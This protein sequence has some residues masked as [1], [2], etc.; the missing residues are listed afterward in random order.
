M[1]KPLR[2]AFVGVKRPPSDM[3]PG[4]WPTFVR[5]HLE[6]P[7]YYARYSACEVVLTTTEKVDYRETFSSGGS[8]RC[9]HEGEYQDS[10]DLGHFDVVVH[11]RKW[12]SD[13]YDHLARN[14]ILSQDHS[15]GPE[16]LQTVKDA[17][18]SEC[19]DGI[20]VFPTWHKENTARELKGIMPRE[21]LYEGMT[22]GVD[23]GVYRPNEN[24]AKRLLWASDPGRGLEALITPFLRLWARDR[25]FSLTVTYPDYVKPE[26]LSRFSSF[27]KHP[28]VRHLPGLRNGQALW[29]IFNM[30]GFLPYSSTFPEPSSRCHR[31]AMASGAV[32]LYPPNMGTPSELIESGLTGIVEDVEHWPDVI[33]SLV[34]TGRRDE[35]A[36]NARS[37][38][39]SE[40]WAVQAKRFHEFFSR[41]RDK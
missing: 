40:D 38:A 29:D 27:L 35:I 25:T 23:S 20:L 33:Q 34:S 10:T 9:I 18:E 30:S 11:W 19:L 21:R 28:G 14:V 31:Q 8:I 16:W 36:H 3:P 7:Y 26:A 39:V 5:F 6:L 2:V 13:L 17:Y 22:L 37:F 1:V 41:G 24:Q 12:H 32:V 15:Y 4:Y